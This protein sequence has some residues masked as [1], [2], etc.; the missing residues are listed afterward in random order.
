MLLYVDLYIK[1]CGICMCRQPVYYAV[2]SSIITFVFSRSHR[3][4]NNKCW[5]HDIITCRNCFRCHL[6][7]P[8][9][10]PKREWKKGNSSEF[11]LFERS[12][13]LSLYTLFS[14]FY[15]CFRERERERVW[16][17]ERKVLCKRH[18]KQ[19]ISNGKFIRFTPFYLIN[20]TRSLIL[21]QSLRPATTKTTTTTRWRMSQSH[22]K[23]MRA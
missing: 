4:I 16:E 22:S 21:F 1:F 10:P 11:V 3:I 2:F 5:K 23:C 9:Q 18:W 12:G 13:L 14:G 15:E 20:K 8:Q 6:H 17:R 7:F 19:W